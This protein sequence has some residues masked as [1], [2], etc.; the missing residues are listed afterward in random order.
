MFLLATKL[1]IV[2][3]RIVAEIRLNRVWTALTLTVVVKV[4]V[5]LVVTFCLKCLFAVPKVWAPKTSCGDP[6]GSHGT[7]CHPRRRRHAEFQP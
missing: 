3:L 5:L 4:I 7:D 2:L 1:N 6:S